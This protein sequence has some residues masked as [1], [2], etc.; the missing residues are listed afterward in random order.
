M[1]AD[2]HLAA[3]N[4]LDRLI[5]W[6]S[7][8]AGARR[9]AARA[10][11]EMLGQFRGADVTTL[12]SDWILPGAVGSQTP[13]AFE[14]S[15]LRERARDAV[16]N[17]PVAVGA[18]DT[19]ANNIVGSGLGPQSRI[20]A[21]VLGI[22]E[23]RAKQ[24]A[25][26]AE[27]AWEVFCKMA[28]ADNR[29][30]MDELQ[31]VALSKIIEDGEV[32]AIPTWADESW[33]PFGRCIELIESERLCSPMSGTANKEIQNGILFGK[34]GQPLKYH[35]RQT[36]SM[37]TVNA[38]DAFDKNGR[39][40][41]LHVF[42]TRRPGQQR[43]IPV[44]APILTRLRDLAKYQEATLVT[45]RVAAC[46]AV[47]ITQQNQFGAFG[48]ERTDAAGTATELA[49]GMITRLRQGD[50]VHVVQPNQPGDNYTGYVDSLLRMI[51]MALGL[52]Y[53]LLVKDFSKT[54]YSSARAALL[55]GRRMFMRWR[56]WF[57]AKLMQPIYEL[58]LEEAFLRGMFDA[59]DFY[60]LRHEYCRALWIGGSWGW[61]DPVKEVEAARKAID[62]GLSNQA[63]ECAAQ[64]RDWEENVD[65]LAR[66]QAYITEKGARIDRS[67]PENEVK[68]DEQPEEK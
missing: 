54:N 6:L 41:V 2:K 9:V 7:P 68:S 56:K 57:A 48:T 58:V 43:G 28:G 11:M 18:L 21:E 13:D 12:R 31:F 24:L 8:A 61:V 53:E 62:Y 47:F 10:S 19:Y 15:A 38:I 46:L 60:A 64:G 20:R 55:E 22:S 23:A 36:G 32:I 33:R 34:R 67:R 45:A 3:G 65:Q 1:S 52:P 49:P 63:E 59:P 17:D 44:F 66:E 37:T 25:R 27:S 5:G 50:G 16:R 30:S 29:L 4:R 51:G 40:K 26:Q 39:P 35:I 14:L 42:A